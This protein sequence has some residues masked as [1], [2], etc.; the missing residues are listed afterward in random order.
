M[1]CI[2]RC[3]A[4]CHRKNVLQ[5]IVFATMQQASEMYV[6]KHPELRIQRETSILQRGA[7]LRPLPADAT[8]YEGSFVAALLHAMHSCALKCIFSV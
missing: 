4:V 1:S 8:P 5:D 6:A 7:S 3:Q 2:A